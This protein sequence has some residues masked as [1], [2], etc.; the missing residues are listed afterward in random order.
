MHRSKSIKKEVASIGHTTKAHD[1][2]VPQVCVDRRNKKNLTEKHPREEAI[3]TA[4]R[5]E[6]ATCEI[7]AK[8][9]PICAEHPLIWQTHTLLRYATPMRLGNLRDNANRS[10]SSRAVAINYRPVFFKRR[11]MLLLMFLTYDFTH[12]VPCC[13]DVHPIS[14]PFSYLFEPCFNDVAPMLHSMF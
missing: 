8:S 13:V 3:D 11:H 4:V 1:I 12:L 6:H 7:C 5:R 14:P 2:G 9:A 10:K